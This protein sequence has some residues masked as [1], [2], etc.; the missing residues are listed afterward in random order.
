MGHPLLAP[1]ILK[2]VSSEVAS[3]LHAWYGE[4][5][6]ACLDDRLLFAPSVTV[7][8][9][10]RDPHSL[11]FTVKTQKS[12]R[13]PTKRLTHLGLDTNVQRHT[14]RPTA[15]CLQHLYDLLDLLPRASL[16]DKEGHFCYTLWLCWPM[17]WPLFVATNLVDD[18]PYWLSHFLTHNYTDLSRPLLPTQSGVVLYTDATPSVVAAVIPGVGPQRLVHRLPHELPTEEA[19]MSAALLGLIWIAAASHRPTSFTLYT[20]STIVNRILAATRRGKTVRRSWRLRI[21]YF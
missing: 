20:D 4:C 6:V 19:E 12:V 15:S 8:E 3:Y 21:L 13:T 11:G 10:L 18:N 2:G 7:H 1:S 5:M 14:I 16:Q 17:V 9:I